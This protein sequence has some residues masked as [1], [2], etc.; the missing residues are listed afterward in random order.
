MRQ[1]AFHRHLET[2][3]EFLHQNGFAFFRFAQPGARQQYLDACRRL[4]EFIEVVGANHAAAGRERHRLEH[5]GKAN[6]TDLRG[7]RTREVEPP[8]TRHRH[9]GLRQPRA[10]Q[11]L[12]PRK[13]HRRGGIVGKAECSC[14]ERG[15]FGAGVV[16]AEHGSERPPLRFAQNGLQGGLSIAEVE[17]QAIGVGTD[18]GMLGLGGDQYFDAA[19]LGRRQERRGAVTVVRG[20]QQNAAWGRIL[21]GCRDRPRNRRRRIRH[22]C[23]YHQP[24]GTP[25]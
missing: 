16:A 20:D 4:R 8:V 10:R 12:A 7:Q 1:Q 13:V 5:T 14:R 15:D 23:L 22:R 2:G 21:D 24:P 19:G 9:A 18:Q 11:V 17:V 3:N 25:C 6:V